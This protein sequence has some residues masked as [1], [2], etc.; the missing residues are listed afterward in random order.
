MGGCYGGLA[1]C[2]GFKGEFLLAFGGSSFNGA[3]LGAFGARGLGDLFC[4]GFG[5]WFGLVL[6]SGGFAGHRDGESLH[7]I[8]QLKVGSTLGVS[9]MTSFSCNS[10]GN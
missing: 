8:V 10:G 3:I 5:S 2:L 1:F 4:G 6:S 7:E 9:E